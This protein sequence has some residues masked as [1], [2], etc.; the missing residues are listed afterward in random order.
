MMEELN[1][2]LYNQQE[3]SNALRTVGKFLSLSRATIG[4]ETKEVAL[5]TNVPLDWIELAEA[6]KEIPE[7]AR[8]I[9]VNFYRY[10]V[11]Y[12]RIISGEEI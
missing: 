12:N 11:G 10:I 5:L 7:Y 9:L 8:Q 6:G 4:L 3:R 2:L 1:R